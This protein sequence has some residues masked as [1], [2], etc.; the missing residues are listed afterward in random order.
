MTGM[1]V[2]E[3][4]ALT[5]FYWDGA[6]AGRLLVTRCVPHGHLSHPPEVSCPVCGSEEVVPVEVS[7][8][9]SVYSFT[10]VRQAFDP[11]FLAELPYV[12]ALVELDEQPGLRVL[13]NIVECDV[14]AVEIGMAVEVTFEARDG[15]AIPQFRPGTS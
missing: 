1:P 13:T 12:V 4:D 14:D 7:G 6:A 15:T 2:P 9:G 8:R 5:A 10:V 3:G 11:A